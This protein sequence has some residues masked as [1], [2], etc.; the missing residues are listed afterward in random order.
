MLVRIEYIKNLFVN[1]RQ[2]S[3]SILGRLSV[4][5]IVSMV[6]LD[7]GANEPKS[8]TKN[9]EKCEHCYMKI[10][11]MRFDT[12]LITS[13]G[14]RFHFDSIECMG[15]YTKNTQDEFK[16]LW[17][18]DFLGS[19]KYIEVQDA[20]FLYSEKIPSPMGAFLSAYLDSESREKVMSEMGGKILSWEDILK[21]LDSSQGKSH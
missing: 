12:Q 18:K 16:K 10:M 6:V 9:Q 4:L 1:A 8:I 13:K 19:G 5:F 15:Q 14:K 21:Q 2:S 17:V 20:Y 7:C 3:L 11:D